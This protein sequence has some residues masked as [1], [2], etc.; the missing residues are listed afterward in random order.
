MSGNTRSL[1]VGRSIT[2]LSGGKRWLAV[3]W[4][5]KITMLSVHLPHSGCTISN[6]RDMLSEIQ[7]F[8]R[9]RP[10]EGILLGMDCNVGL[11]GVWDKDL[12]GTA[13][14]GRIGNA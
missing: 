14:A 5:K 6:F 11:A 7:Q 4:W 12:V 13:V 1:K 8:F 10:R 3:S 9:N 2:F